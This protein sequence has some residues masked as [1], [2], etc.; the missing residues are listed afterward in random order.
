MKKFIFNF[1]IIVFLFFNI[2]SFNTNL[3]SAQKI[4]CE[5]RKDDCANTLF[6]R[7]YSNNNEYEG[8]IFAQT[9]LIRDMSNEDRQFLN[10]LEGQSIPEGD[11]RYSQ[12]L[13]LTNDLSEQGYNPLSPFAPTQIIELIFNVFGILKS[14]ISK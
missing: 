9:F 11:S 13:S 5:I 4:V 8:Y 6:L 14:F 7:K 2:S 12:I 10:Q 3:V 1:V